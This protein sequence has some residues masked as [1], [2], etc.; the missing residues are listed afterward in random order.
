MLYSLTM[1]LTLL[2]LADPASSWVKLLD[3]LAPDINVIVTSD[4]ERIKE[5][6][7]EA[8]VLLNGGFDSRLLD[9]ALP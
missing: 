1:A 2:V 8:D 6:A 3:H 7:E 9:A 5:R 4:I